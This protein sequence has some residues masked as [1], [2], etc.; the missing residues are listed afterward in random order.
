VALPAF[1]PGREPAVTVQ[2]AFGRAVD[3]FAG[4]VELPVER[5]TTA[6]VFPAGYEE[7]DWFRIVGVEQAIALGRA[8]VVD[9][10]DRLDPDFRRAMTAAL[11]VSIGD[12]VAARERRYRY[13]RDLAGALGDTG[14]L[15]TPTLT[16]DGWSADG[17]LP[18]R[19]RP[20]VPDWAFNTDP[21]NLTGRPAVSVP[22]GLLPSGI[23]FGLQL[24]GPR[25]GDDRL[26]DLAAA[27]ELVQPWP[28]TAPGY[29]VFGA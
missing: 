8:T 12:H 10:A 27:W 14:V 19:E 3:A 1:A 7:D 21:A 4:A 6:D 5:V 17:R 15:V 23:P 2:A 29:R 20:G 26:L 25:Y 16:L 13:A 22:A 11:E 24:I 28:L 9:A 18:G